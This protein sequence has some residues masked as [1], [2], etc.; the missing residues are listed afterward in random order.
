MAKLERGVSEMDRLRELGAALA[1][2][3]GDA[4]TAWR[5]RR[6]DEPGAR[7]MM[8]RGGAARRSARRWSL[9]LAGGAL[10]ALL[11]VV[12]VGPLVRHGWPAG[13]SAPPPGTAEAAEIL[14]TAALVAHEADLPV[15][16][17]GQF[18]FTETVA[19]PINQVQQPDGGFS[20]AQG[21]RVLRQ[22][23]LSADGTRDG[24]VRDR[25]Y[26][27]DRAASDELALPACPAVSSADPVPGRPCTPQPGFDAGMPDSPAA[28]L[29]WLRAG[30][31]SAAG[32][33]VA[34]AAAAGGGV[35]D[36]L[37][38]QRAG[39]LLVG[40]RYLTSGQRSALFAALASLPGVTV[41][42]QV[43]DLANRDG[44][45]VGMT[46]GTTLIFD[47]TSY[48]FLGT[49]NSA[50]LRQATVDEAGDVPP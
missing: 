39:E 11:V 14:R 31:S 13:G 33:P 5:S 48:A 29:D 17:A 32:P 9:G 28:L 37:V 15:P 21:P 27:Q 26:Q 42:Q 25:P 49:T 44:V 43:R 47:A 41:Q 8:R 2:D 40:G 38:F 22:T 36:A 16:R 4:P 1:P 23:W 30:V 34:S 3:A 18:V 12:T 7:T 6:L 50:L 45:G 24:L 10:A 20:T 46:D 19:S 35:A